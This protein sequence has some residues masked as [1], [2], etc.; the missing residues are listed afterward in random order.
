M[1]ALVDCNNFF[2]SCEKV[3]CPKLEGKPVVVLSGNDGIIIARSKEA[4]AL[5]IPMGGPVFEY[6][7]LFEKYNVHLFSSNFSLYADMSR[8]VMATLHTL[9]ETMDI[10]SVDEAF[11]VCDHLSTSELAA[12]G[13]EIR[14]K[15]LLWTGISV[16]VGI[17]PTKTLTKAAN[18]FA[19]RYPKF[20]GVAAITEDN[21]RA[22][23]EKLPVEEVWGVGAK[24][25]ER[26]K[27]KRIFT[28]WDLA[29]QQDSFLKKEL[30]V[31]GL[32]LAWEL[33]GV[34]CS[35]VDG[36]RESRKSISTARSFAEPLT[37][38]TS[39]AEVLS[40]YAIKIAEELR[41]E[42]QY[43][44]SLSVWLVT[45]DYQS[46]SASI[47]MPESTS[48]T[49]ELITSALIVLR[50]LFKEGLLYR[51]VGIMAL[52]LVPGNP[53]QQDLFA[54][55][56]RNSWEKEEKI[57]QVVDAINAKHGAGILSFAAAGIREKESKKKRNC[58]PR[59][60]T[61]WDELLEIG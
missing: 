41:E 53:R 42:K 34:A 56:E 24:L 19:K 30:S 4:K 9:C 5:G 18:Y 15:V 17:A 28:A 49:P 25:S 47:T 38:L 23:L 44:S 33:R 7:K 2:V 13:Q 52:G 54:Q 16:S 29:I 59:Y 1:L 36:M 31:V 3:F 32:R 60:T 10:N 12:Y 27:K 58:S 50:S 8:R 46:F 48:Y 37:Q 61:S 45:K 20:N 11:L 51:K 26:L 57:M 55:K 43:A 22:C 14:E 39:I 40:S 21:R 6:K 35:V